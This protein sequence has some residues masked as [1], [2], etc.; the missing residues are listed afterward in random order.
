VLAEVEFAG[1]VTI[2]EAFGDECYDLFLARSE[3]LVA[4]GVEHAQRG[5]F[6]DQVEQERHL[7]GVGPDLAIGNPL[8]APA[9]QPEMR[10]RDAEN[11]A[12]AG[13]ER[14][15]HQAAVVGLD[16]E[17]L[18]NG[19]VRKMN[20]AHRR[21]LVGDVDGVIEREHNHFGGSGGN[22]LKDGGD[23]DWAG[24]DAELGAAA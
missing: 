14:A 17:N 16:Q 9:K 18:G 3:E 20:A 15:H 6:G 21:H 24:R 19:R 8:D 23:I 12:S 10:V 22:R 13:A 4:A 2:A 5:Y 1:S 7:F 11:A